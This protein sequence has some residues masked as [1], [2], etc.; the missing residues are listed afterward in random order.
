MQCTVLNANN[1]AAIGQ[2]MTALTAV[3]PRVRYIATDKHDNATH[4]AHPGAANSSSDQSNGWQLDEQ[5]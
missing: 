1:A 2:G 3:P 5:W 4:H